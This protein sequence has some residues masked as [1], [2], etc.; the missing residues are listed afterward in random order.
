MGKFPV[1]VSGPSLTQQ[2][3]KDECDINFIVERAKRGAALPVNPR[4][5]F[6]GDFTQVPTDLRE[7]LVEV[8]KAESAFMS[9]DAQ[10]RRRFEN[11]P[12]QLL[13]FLND[14]NNR[15]EAI[16]LGLVKAPVVP[17]VDPGETG[18]SVEIRER[19]EALESDVRDDRGD[20]IGDRPIKSSGSK[21][22]KA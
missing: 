3:G 1:D 5:P 18:D 21:K 10:V 15:A 22:L 2:S 11:D 9:L 16:S 13:D 12:A 6:Y 7:C 20:S 17:P 19:L 8:K 14:P 4:E